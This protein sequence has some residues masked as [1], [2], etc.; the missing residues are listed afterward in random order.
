MD[1]WQ[2]NGVAAGTWLSFPLLYHMTMCF[3][4][5]KKIFVDIVIL[6]FDQPL[7]NSVSMC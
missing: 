6:F 3:D 1:T 4:K 2:K 7:D 5:Q